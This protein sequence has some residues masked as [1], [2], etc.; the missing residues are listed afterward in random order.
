MDMPSD[1]RSSID[2]T[3]T[4]R[5]CRIHRNDRVARSLEEGANL[6]E[7]GADIEYNSWNGDDEK[8]S[9]AA[10][11]P[12][13]LQVERN[14]ARTLLDEISLQQICDQRRGM[15]NIDAG[16]SKASSECASQPLGE[17]GTE[18]EIAD[19]NFVRYGGLAEYSSYFLKGKSN[20]KSKDGEE[21]RAA[22]RKKS[23]WGNTASCDG[24][25]A[26]NNARDEEQAPFELSAEKLK[27]MPSDI[28]F[29]SG[30]VAF[31]MWVMPSILCRQS[32]RGSI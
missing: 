20:D 23:R 4:G 18:E 31:A 13:A 22:T 6:I 1:T 19:R 11:R 28:P 17:E 5:K 14:D 26:K 25:Q 15:D 32:F 9:I 29:V 3:I 30:I 27:G 7:L 2:L 10:P 16:V 8:P 21:V 12:P 24:K